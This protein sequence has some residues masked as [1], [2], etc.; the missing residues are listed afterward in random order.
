MPA[1]FVPCPADGSSRYLSTQMSLVAD[2]KDNVEA[3]GATKMTTIKMTTSTTSNSSP[4]PGS[5][6]GSG[7]GTGSGWCYCPKWTLRPRRWLYRGEGNS[8]LCLA[9]PR[10]SWISYCHHQH[11][12]HYYYH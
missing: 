10:V 5:G 1:E 9:L 7:L 12:Y 4:S 3:D 6:L 11:Y 8:S 2:D